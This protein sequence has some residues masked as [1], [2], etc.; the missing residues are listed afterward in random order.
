MKT[1]RSPKHKL[2]IQPT[3]KATLGAKRNLFSGKGGVLHVPN[4]RERSG[5][6]SGYESYQTHAST[7]SVPD[8]PTTSE[9]ERCYLKMGLKESLKTCPPLVVQQDIESPGDYG[10]TLLFEEA[11][12]ICN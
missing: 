8:V 11:Q 7:P 4:Q 2:G 6:G 3:C 1:L 10:L 12:L 5:E 9:E